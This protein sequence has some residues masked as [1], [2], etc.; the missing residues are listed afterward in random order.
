MQKCA[1]CGQ[2]DLRALSTT[3]L[4]RG[5]VVVVCG[6]HELMHRRSGRTA[7]SLSDLQAM[8][9]DRREARRRYPIADELG[10]RL[11]EAFSTNRRSDGDRRVG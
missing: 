10:A 11:M 2:A 5:E 9:R 1:I 4:A 8:V 7:E 3:R 6:T